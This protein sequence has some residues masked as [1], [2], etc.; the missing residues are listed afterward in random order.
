M[1]KLQKEVEEIFEKALAEA[2]RSHIETL[3]RHNE[4]MDCIEKALAPAK[5]RGHKKS[6]N[7]IVSG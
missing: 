5:H 4:I 6:V 1:T 7:S 3:K 2:D